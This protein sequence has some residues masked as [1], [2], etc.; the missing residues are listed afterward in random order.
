MDDA[1][2]VTRA[3]QGEAKT[4][5]VILRTVSLLKVFIKDINRNLEE[6]RKIQSDKPGVHFRSAKHHL[7]VDLG[8]GF[9]CMMYNIT[10]H[11]QILISPCATSG[12]RFSRIFQPR[13]W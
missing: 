8:M 13:A 1:F 11:V 12:R 5:M 9:C 3:Q 7:E 2:A 10:V 6:I 4:A